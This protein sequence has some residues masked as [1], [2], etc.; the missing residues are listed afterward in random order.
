MGRIKEFDREQVLR[1]AMIVFWEKG[2]EGTSI[3]DLLESMGLS[4][5]SL[6]ETFQDKQTLYY[7]A[8]QCYKKMSQKKRDLMIH[9]PSAIDGIRQY[10]ELH[11]TNA[12]AAH[13]EA[14]PNGCLITNAS[15]GVEALDE[16]LQNT[17][18]HRFTELERLFYETL[19]KGQEAGEIA[20]DKDIKMFAYLLLN[21]N[22]SINVMAKVQSDSA[23]VRD[24]M[25]AVLE[26]L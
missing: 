24:M 7:E 20:P 19:K 15:I 11:I 18:R 12:F 21:L 10:F 13:G 6:Y 17:I 22:H 4:R 23:K 14:Y 1:K 26:M 16:P 5:S 9:A 2:Y 25:N 3:P 8:I